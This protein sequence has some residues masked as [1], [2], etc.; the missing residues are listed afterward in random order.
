MLAD[1]QHAFR[2]AVLGSED[3]KIAERIAS[4][5][6][7]AT[8]RLEIYRNTVQASLTDVL[9]TAFPVVN[10]VVGADYFTHLARLF[11]VRHP[12]RKAQ[13]SEYGAGFPSFIAQDDSHGLP[14]LADVAR[15]E[16][17]RGM[18]YFAGDDPHLDPADLVRVDGDLTDFVFVLHPATTR[19]H[20]AFPVV[21]I[22]D[23]NQPHN[24]AVPTMDMKQSETG[25]VTRPS[26]QVAT[27]CIS[28]GDSAFIDSLAKGETLSVAAEAALDCE[29]GF[30]FQNALHLHLEN[31]TFTAVHPD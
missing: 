16:W 26:M 28:P 15:L 25:I 29:P 4:P 12:P 1:L 13:L 31:G 21:T 17:A 3:G 11:V 10:R 18:A 7:N 19:I 5:R 2:A 27:R 20:S 22:W 14:Y 24:A 9:A 23:V 6:G 8:T 30:D